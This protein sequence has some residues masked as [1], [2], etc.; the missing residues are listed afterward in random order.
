MA[1]GFKQVLIVALLLCYTS[2]FAQQKNF[3]LRTL[4]WGYKIVQG[5][6]AK[7]KKKYLFIVPIVSY[8]PETRWQLGVSTSH[9]F[10]AKNNDS[11]TRPSVIR[12]NVSYTQNNQLSIRPMFEVFT[13]GNK[14]SLRG[15]LQY[16]NF[17]ENYWGIGNNTQESNKE[18]YSFNQYKANIKATRL[19]KKGIY[20]GLQVD[21]EKLYNIKH[22]SASLMALSNVNGVN[23]YHYFGLGPVFTFDNRNQIYFPTKG[24]IVDVS[25]A[26]R[27]KNVGSSSTFSNFTID[28]RKYF[29]LWNDN[30]LALQAYGSF[31][32]GDVPYRAMGTLGN[33]SYFRGYYYGR[34]RDKHELSIQAELRKQIWGPVGM[35][36]FGGMGNVASS[37]EKLNQFIKPMYG[38]G[39]RVKAIPREKINFRIDYA[40]G[41]HGL[42][43]FYV[44]LNEAF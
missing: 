43:A 9:F 15:I 17:I 1:L 35:V 12:L 44:T 4:D 38:I 21:Y 31:N 23:G 16:S 39:L 22:E 10:R 28:A 3:V 27:N 30:V 25:A 14:Y 41:H 7:P 33:E 26:I 36:A 29:G 13:T 20:L 2:M 8:K 32:D 42:Q 19:I 6:S 11:I 18:L 34:Y 5:D 24:H 37:P 40:R